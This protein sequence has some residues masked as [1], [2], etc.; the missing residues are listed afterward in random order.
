MYKTSLSGSRRRLAEVVVNK[1]DPLL[2]DLFE[3]D[4]DIGEYKDKSV[5]ESPI[6]AYV[7]INR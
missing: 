5:N 1:D 6:R 3:I 7:N 4:Y 2:K